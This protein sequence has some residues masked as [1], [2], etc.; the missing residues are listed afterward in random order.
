MTA[1][2]SIMLT[3]HTQKGECICERM[4]LMQA[5]RK[6]NDAVDVGRNA[7]SSAQGKV[8]NATAGL[9]E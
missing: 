5:A 8:L 9:A 2:A 1:T 6:A 7:S 3:E 4:Q